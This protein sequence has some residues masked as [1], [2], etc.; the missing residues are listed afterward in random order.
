MREANEN[1][2]QLLQ[3][4]LTSQLSSKNV[5]MRERLTSKSLDWVLGEIKSKFE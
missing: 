2:T 4:Y 1:S 5:I 3:I